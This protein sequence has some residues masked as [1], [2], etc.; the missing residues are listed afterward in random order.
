MTG[1]E[2]EKAIGFILDQQGKFETQQQRFQEELLQRRRE[3][4]EE[5]LQ[6]RRE[7]EEDRKFVR[8]VMSD[9]ARG[10]ADLTVNAEADRQEFRNA[11]QHINEQAEEDRRATRE[12]ISVVVEQTNTTFQRVTERADADRAAILAIIEEVRAVNQRVSKLES[13]RNGK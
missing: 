4:E 9:M 7:A 6:L 2:M 8:E 5:L 1:E 12:M 3:A 10:I 13:E 11:I